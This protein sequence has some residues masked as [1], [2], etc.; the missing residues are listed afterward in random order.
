VI[1]V[2]RG[3]AAADEE[4]MIRG[5]TAEQIGLAF[6]S[7]NNGGPGWTDATIGIVN[8]LARAEVQ[9]ANGNA[10]EPIRALVAALAN[11]SATTIDMPTPTAEPDEAPGQQEG[12]DISD[13]FEGVEGED[14]PQDGDDGEATEETED[15]PF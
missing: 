14:Q 5:E 4:A 12:D 10:P 9:A 1:E 3:A 7:T 6:G 11:Y 15:P 2:A 13:M 8:G